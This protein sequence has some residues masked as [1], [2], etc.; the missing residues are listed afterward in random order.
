MRLIA[1][2]L[3]CGN[4][5]FT[6]TEHKN[7][8]GHADGCHLDQTP[9]A[10][11]AAK[12]LGVTFEDLAEA[13]TTR[14]IRAGNEIVH[15][16]M[17]MGQS[18][19]ACEALMKATYGAA[20]DF[21]VAKVNESISSYQ[22]QAQNN[23]A[24]IGVLDI[25]GFETF[26]SN[27]FEQI[28]INYTNEALQQQFNKYVFKLEQE[29]YEREGILWKF[30]SFPDNQEILDLIDKKHTGIFATLDEQCIVPSSDQK[31]TRFLYSKCEKHP[32]FG[33]NAGQKVHHKFTIE[34]YAGPVEYGTE[35]WLEKN[36]DQMPSASVDLL[37]GA[38]FEL[39]VAAQ[40]SAQLRELRSRIDTTV[41]HYI[42]CLKPNDELV[43]NYF[44]P[45]MIV[46]QL[47]CGGVLEAVRVSRAGYSTR[48]P[49]DVFKARYSFLGDCEI[50]S[51]KPMRTNTPFGKKLNA[52]NSDNNSI[53]KL[54][55]KIALDI[56]EAENKSKDQQENA[57][58]IEDFLSLDFSSRC[59]LAG[60]QLG[61]TKVFLRREAFDRI[62]ALR[63]KKFG[64]AA[65]TIQK[66]VRG[67]Q[68]RAS[69]KLNR[70]SVRQP[71]KALLPDHICSFSS[72][73]DEYM[74]TA[75]SVSVDSRN[76]SEG[77]NEP[78][79]TELRTLHGCHLDQTPSA[80]A[81]AKLLGVTFED[82]AEALTTRA[83]RAGNEIVHTPMDM[84]Q[85]KKACEALMKA[86]YGAAFDF[87]VA[88]VNE[89]I[90]S[91][92]PQAQ[93]NSAS[94]GVLDIFGFETFESN[95]FEQICINYTNEALQQQFNKYVFKLEQEEYEREGILWKFISFP[96]NQEILDLI[97]KKH[98]G[99]FATLDEQCIVPSSDQKFTRFLYSKCEKHPRFGANA[100]QKVHHK[101]TIEHYAGPVEYGTE[102]WLEKNKDQM[103]SA[104]VDL[105]KGANFELLV[106]AQFS[107]QLRELRSRIDT[108][109]PHYIR[110]LKPNDELVPN[111]FDPKMIVEQ[112]RCGGVLEAVRVSRAG[113]STRYP[114]DV[115]K[116]RYSFLGDCE[117]RSLKPMRT[118]TPF[119]KKLNAVNSDN[120]SIKKL[121]GKIALDIWEAENKSKDQQENAAPIEDFLSL[122]FS[123]RCAL[124]GLQLGRT[125]VFLR[126]EAF[127][128]IE[129]L[130]AKKFGKA[131]V[132][133]QKI[134]RGVQARASY[135]LNRSSVRQP[136][137]ALLPDHICS[138]S[139]MRDEYMR[140]ASSVSVDS[141]NDSEGANEPQMT[142]LRT[143]RSVEGKFQVW[144]PLK[145]S[146]SLLTNSS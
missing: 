87:I 115:F 12:L 25:F 61:R 138:F 75:S 122:D 132:T 23:S 92:Q 102:G 106:A 43:P 94:I 117:I 89:S 51:L 82:L 32:R 27:N 146:G 145:S 108:T 72:M 127:D 69:Y 45:K 133:I 4:M 95:N 134:V 143:L 2:I 100:G 38:N 77:A 74:R 60:L 78:Q 49:H 7:A 53:K 118:N 126:R 119:G 50:R 142:E 46:E 55:G 26:E 63:A 105:L 76:D 139:S 65:V 6:S 113:Y 13:L 3:H 109:V 56:W 57:A 70:S 90:S 93:N 31:F 86:T 80:L 137:K 96:D 44:D 81:A 88:K 124:A 73:R 128:R 52:V 39:L 85:S 99:I 101:F 98:T 10:L 8:R 131:A 125:K 135:K 59:A 30:I 47:R 9:S 66:I 91:Y 21:I 22:P 104:S 103:P 130:R 48:Y 71:K 17:D 1:A 5:T 36:K 18:K 67:V 136:K 79:M 110:C 41:P 35:G 120:N 97:D 129:A 141:R 37:K 20:F 121:I 28:C 11:A 54:I 42:R 14:A 15:T 114:H 112:L 40:F 144:P 111:Y 33:A 83:I 140:T 58:P 107:A 29:E 19:K 84:G 68:A 62:E 34:H 16:P 64:K 116:A 123:S 24:S